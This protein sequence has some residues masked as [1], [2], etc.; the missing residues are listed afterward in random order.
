LGNILGTVSSGFIFNFGWTT[1]IADRTVDEV[2]ID[3]EDDEMSS[4]VR[5]VLLSSSV[6]EDVVVVVVD[7]EEVHISWKAV[8]TVPSSSAASQGDF[9]NFTLGPPNRSCQFGFT[10]K[11]I[12]F[13][14]FFRL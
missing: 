9:T 6:V 8:D 13:V 12:W 14:T 1:G 11:S 2:V 5:D 10:I 7:D 4:R 3:E